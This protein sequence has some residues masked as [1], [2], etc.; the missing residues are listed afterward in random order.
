VACPG[1]GTRAVR[2]RPGAPVR[3]RPAPRRRHRR[4]RGRHGRRA[5]GRHRD[6]RRHRPLQ[7]QVADDPHRRWAR[8][9]AHASRLARRGQGRRGGGGRSGRHRR[10]E[11]DA[12]DRRSLRPSGRPARRERAGL[13]RSSR[14]PAR[15]DA[16]R[17]C[18]RAACPQGR[19]AGRKRTGR[20]GSDAG[21][22]GFRAVDG[23]RPTGRGACARAGSGTG[24]PRT[25]GTR[26]GDPRTGGT[27]TCR[28]GSSTGTH[29]R[30]GAG[31]ARARGDTRALSCAGDARRR[32]RARAARPAG[33]ARAARTLGAADRRPGTP[34]CTGA[35]SRTAH[36]AGT[37]RGRLAGPARRRGSGSRGAPCRSGSRAAPRRP[38]GA[39]RC[40]DPSGRAVPAGTR[41]ARDATCAARPRTSCADDSSWPARTVD[42]LRRRRGRARSAA[43]ARSYDQ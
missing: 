10:V 22:R 4:C 33:R 15:G 26:T 27:R 14:P 41:S 16:A 8:R 19:A 21:A 31:C 32:C 6:V 7:R 13:R 42:R 30:A 28:G 29:G 35:G 20:A 9:D 12:G 24:E 37:D 36:A 25:R 1:T 34:S 39:C 5:G 23:A 18:R 11:R 2:L 40:R 43:D 17:A 38:Q 3:C